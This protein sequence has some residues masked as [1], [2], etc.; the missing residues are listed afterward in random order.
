[1][2]KL[3]LSFLAFTSIVSLS[4]TASALD[5]TGYHKSV[6]AEDILALHS[7]MYLTEITSSVGATFA[8]P[9]RVE[10]RHPTD[11]RNPFDASSDE[12]VK[13]LN[14]WSATRMKTCGA[15]DLVALRGRYFFQLFNNA[16]GRDM[17][18]R[19]AYKY[20][21]KNG[22]FNK[23]TEAAQLA[24]KA[25][26]NPEAVAMAA[27]KTAWELVQ[28]NES[29]IRAD[30][31]TAV[32]FDVVNIF[33]D[34]IRVHELL[35]EPIDNHSIDA[36]LPEISKYYIENVLKIEAEMKRLGLI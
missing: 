9:E 23:A 22:F 35:K 34:W 8:R 20:T 5:V 11:P 14:G 4:N 36:A 30:I 7:I 25:G 12:A 32:T 2:K 15:A 18:E 16:D 6:L 29:Q 10:P 3:L 28:A 27:A 17:A 31:Y 26:G 33:S 21:H 13:R 1:M 19:A 24:Y